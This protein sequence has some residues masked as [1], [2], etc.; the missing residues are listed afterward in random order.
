MQESRLRELRQE[1]ERVDADYQRLLNNPDF[2]ELDLVAEQLTTAALVI[3][4]N[5]VE[6]LPASAGAPETVNEP[7]PT[8]KR[9]A[10]RKPS[11]A[12]A[13]LAKILDAL[14]E[15]ARA[16]QQEFDRHAMPGPLGVSWKDEGSFHW[17]CARIYPIFKRAQTTFKK[18]RA[19][20]CAMGAYAKPT[21]FYRRALPHIAPKLGG[22]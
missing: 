2:D 14:E 3:T 20:V 10:G 4:P 8:P 22:R 18:H 17:L 6:G 5:Y 7:A 1:F 15:Y 16:T 12:K 9:K 11:V 19:R 21:D 13:K